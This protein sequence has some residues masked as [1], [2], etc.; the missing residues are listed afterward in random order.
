M[1]TPGAKQ[2]RPLRSKL[3]PKR[4]VRK[5]AKRLFWIVISCSKKLKIM[6]DILNES[7]GQLL[8]PASVVATVRSSLWFRLCCNT[9]GNASK[10]VFRKQPTVRKRVYNPGFCIWTAPFSVSSR[11]KESSKA[12]SSSALSPICPA[13]LTSPPHSGQT[14]NSFSSGQSWLNL[15]LQ[16]RQRNVTF[17]NYR[18]YGQRLQNL[19]S[20]LFAP[21]RE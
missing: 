5:R 15:W 10:V 13:N 3:S 8:Q 17:I 14:G 9:S 16:S 19:I 4:S 12:F 7:P 6:L 21:L 18:L 1:P 11:S 2:S 20:R